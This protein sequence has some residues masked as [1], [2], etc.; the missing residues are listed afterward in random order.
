MSDNDFERKAAS[1]V[2]K[3][4]RDIQERIDRE[5]MDSLTVDM[6]CGD[7]IHWGQPQEPFDL[8][9]LAALMQQMRDTPE[10]RFLQTHHIPRGQ[11]LEWK[12]VHRD[13]KTGQA[14]KQVF[15]HPDDV[16]AV[17]AALLGQMVSEPSI[18]RPMLPQGL[19]LP[20]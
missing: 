7:L 14:Y 17:R 2:E 20:S 12:E 11:M 4:Q 19:E 10:L 13:P 18:L 5:V 9:R 15:I 6:Q 1:L 3:M 8:G 16:P